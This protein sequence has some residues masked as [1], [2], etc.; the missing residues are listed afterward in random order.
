M[1]ED[2]DDHDAHPDM[3]ERHTGQPRNVL[4]GDQGRGGTDVFFAAVR[5]TRMPMCLSDPKQPDS[6]LVF[7]NRAFEDL[8]GYT[9][10]EVLGRNCRFLQGPDT[11]PG[12]V[13]EVR[14]AIAARVDVSV[15]LY[16]YRKDGSGFWDALYISPVFDEAGEL[17]YFFASQ[18]DV[19]R[20]REAEALAQQGLRMDALGSMAAG[21]AHEFGNM[22]TIVRGS[23]EQARRNPSSDRQAEQLARAEWGAAQAARLTQQMLNFAHWQA[24]ALKLADLGELVRNMDSLMR[25]VAG[26][27]IAL[28]MEAPPEPLPVLVDAGQVELAVFNLVQNA[29]AAMAQPSPGGST[30]EVSARPGD[31]TLT[32]STR[33]LYRGDA[34]AFAVLEVADT[35]SGM[36]P[37]VA[38]RA[39]EPFFSTKG[40]GKGTGLGLSMVRDC[41][42][43]SGGGLEIDS[44]LGQGTRIRIVLPI[45]EGSAEKR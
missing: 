39:A 18:L 25:Q 20:R 36:A 14:R 24:P 2:T 9:A 30:P 13:D 8:T 6:P 42:E 26:I 27:N 44:V 22:M 5:M 29:A 31:R 38:R 41:A 19:T 21:V 17:L 32:I 12:A 34:G 40:R 4:L 43:Q 33:R 16:N 10:E 35:G 11:D 15:E 7:V 45:S 28:T 1:A 3:R 23:L 37:E